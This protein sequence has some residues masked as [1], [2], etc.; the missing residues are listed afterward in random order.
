MTRREDGFV[1]LVV[2]WVLAVLTVVTV[3]FG[4]RSLMDQRAAAYALDQTQA[5]LMARGAVYR[6]IL[7]LRNKAV[8][9][10]AEMDHP[11]VTHLGQEWAKPMDLFSEGIFEGKEGVEGDTCAFVIEDEQAKMNLNSIPFEVLEEV[12]ALDRSVLR[13]IK[14]RRTEGEQDGE[15]PAPFHAP[16]ELRYMRGVDYEEWYGDR[17]ETGLRNLFTTVGTER[18]NINTARREVLECIPDCDDQAINA[19]LGYRAG[20]DGEVGTQDDVGFLDWNDFV[21]RTGIS[22]ESLTA[23]KRYGDLYSTYY[24]VTGIATKRN[25]QV[26][27]S[28]TATVVVMEGQ[29]SILDWR[30]RPL[31]A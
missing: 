1:L 8:T 24:T 5:M 28:V 29:A 22:G 15:G 11:P 26:R 30:E 17:K 10:M 20:P 31:G 16:E 21:E 7:L 6:G 23:L 12:E 25:G 14:A 3:G 4:R 19:V 27:A 2:L 9:D 18:V 13:R